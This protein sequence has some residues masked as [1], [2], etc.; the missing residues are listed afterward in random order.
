MGLHGPEKGSS[1]DVL[2]EARTGQRKVQCKEIH[3]SPTPMGIV[4]LID[5]YCFKLEIELLVVSDQEFSCN[6]L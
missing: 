4:I 6:K 3:E 5:F 1:A 2:M